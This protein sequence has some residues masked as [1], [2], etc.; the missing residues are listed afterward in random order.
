MIK[1]TFRKETHRLKGVSIEEGWHK[2]CPAD[3]EFQCPNFVATDAKKTHYKVISSITNL[4]V[5]E[6]LSIE[7][8]R[9]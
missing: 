7:P 2:V 4:P 6:V 5:G 8:T 1:I 9:T 3:A